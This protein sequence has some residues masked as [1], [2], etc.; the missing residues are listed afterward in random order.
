MLVETVRQIGNSK[1]VAALFVHEG[2]PYFGLP[3]VDPW[4][5]SRDATNYAGPCPVVAHPPCSRWC[6]LAG[7]VE[8]RWGHKRGDDG[9]LFEF[10]LDAVR[11]W[12]GVL[13]HPAYS[14]AWGAYGLNRPP[15][16]GGWI[17]ADFEGG[18]TCHVEQGR[19]GHAA[20]KATWL[21]AHGVDVQSMRW[22]TAAGSQALVSWCANHTSKFEQRPRLG[23]VAA[24]KTPEI[25]RD[26][27]LTLARTHVC[28]AGFTQDGSRTQ[29]YMGQVARSRTPEAF[30][31]EL[32]RLARTKA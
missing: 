24:A 8:A 25:F 30:R 11:R 17:V 4:P 19:Y 14:D 31:D 28:D 20:K 21:Y 18:W 27:L 7:M 12:G 13:E 23:K 5:E 10:A 26:E 2:G 9:G 1:R 29:Q 32:I 22:G 6:R 15:A 3:D 16:A